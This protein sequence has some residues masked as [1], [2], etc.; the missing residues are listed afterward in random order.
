MRKIKKFAS[1]LLAAALMLVLCVPAFAAGEGYT[2]TIIDG[3]VSG[4]T[5]VA[6][7]LMD[8]TTATTGSGTTTYAYTVN[9]KYSVLLRSVTGETSDEDVISYIASLEDDDSA[10]RLLADKLYKAILADTTF[11][12]DAE[13][14]NEEFSGLKGYYLIAES[15]P[16][17]T[18]NAGEN[19]SYSLAILRTV[20]SDMEITTKESVPQLTKEVWETNDSTYSASNGEWQDAADY[21]IGDSVPFRLE[22]TISSQ[23][24]SFTTYTLTFHDTLSSGLT[25]DGESSVKVYVVNNNVATQ[26][27]TNDY[28]VTTST[29]DSC[30][31]HVTVTNL[32]NLE[33]NVTVTSAS[34]VRVEYT[35]KLNSNA[36]IGQGS[37]ST[38]QGN[39][40]RAYLQ[41]SNNPYDDSD[42]GK[43]PEDKVTVFTFK[44]DAKKYGDSTS[45]ELTG[46]GFTLY[47]W[48]ATGSGAEDGSWV[49]VGTPQNN[50]SGNTF[51]WKGL[52][53]GRYKIVET[54]VPS[55]YT[56]AEDI[57]FTVSATY[58]TDS[59]NPRLT[60]V[61]TSLTGGTNSVVGGEITTTVD[62]GTLTAGIYN[63]SGDSLPTTG[64]I[65]TTIFYIVGGV[66]VCGAA[67]LL[68]TKKRM[69]DD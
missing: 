63:K 17:A 58:D 47:K 68:I 40:N 14:G 31:F 41:Y 20:A 25:F 22:A 53:S 34:V 13:T 28:T 29:G 65:G 12:A 69:G 27:S 3:D 1:V 51:S 67:V 33:T 23:Y 26:L 30:S 32:K 48:V 24:S 56:K 45:T 38:N 5:Y 52:D 54:T 2:V 64:G 60:A 9:S 36:V 35:A 55:G 7:K 4:A 57:V 46:A 19:E 62:T 10:V 18:T 44:L 50:T 6:Y 39:P 43:T 11:T 21:D 59:D 61:T 8:V 15:A 37:D 66:L 42:T 16:G 49:M